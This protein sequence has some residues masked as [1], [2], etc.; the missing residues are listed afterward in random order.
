[1][2][3]TIRYYL[4]NVE[5]HRPRRFPWSLAVLLVLL[6]V[7]IQQVLMHGPLL[8]IDQAAHDQLGGGLPCWNHGAAVQTHWSSMWLG[9][10]VLEMFGARGPTAIFVAAC[11]GMIGWHMRSWRPLVVLGAGLFALNGLVGATKLFTERPKPCNGIDYLFVHGEAFPS[12]HGANVVVTWGILVYLLIAYA[13]WRHRATLWTVFTLVCVGVAFASVCL[14]TH[15]TSDLIAGWLTGGVIL[16]AVVLIDTH[17]FI[18]KASVTE[19]VDPT[20]RRAPVSHHEIP[21]PR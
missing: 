21:L 9:L 11:A 4:R 2:I 3:S 15:W 10:K 20:Q 13:G 18:R 8:Q 19:P 6:G 14:D 5:V 17:V 16:R 1:M 7:S 12:G